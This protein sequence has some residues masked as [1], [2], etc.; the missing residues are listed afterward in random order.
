MIKISK[1]YGL[2]PALLLALTFPAQAAWLALSFDQSPQAGTVA[3]GPKL[4]LTFANSNIN[5]TTFTNADLVSRQW[6]DLEHFGVMPSLFAATT[7][8]VHGT[9]SIDTLGKPNL[10]YGFGYTEERASSQNFNPLS[11]AYESGNSI[12]GP[13]LYSA[14]NGFYLRLY[15]DSFFY[16]GTGTPNNLGAPGPQPGTVP[17]PGTV[18]M[19]LAGLLGLLGVRMRRHV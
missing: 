3:Y 1:T 6:A 17:E 18:S 10:D 16:S 9:V 15:I 4:T 7:P 5:D 14:G 12:Y 8:T 2:L 11:L 13:L 19:L